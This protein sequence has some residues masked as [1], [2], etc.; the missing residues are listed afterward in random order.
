[1]RKQ[2]FVNVRPVSPQV[3]AAVLELFAIMAE[4]TRNGDLVKR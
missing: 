1:M 3:S 2:R 4:L